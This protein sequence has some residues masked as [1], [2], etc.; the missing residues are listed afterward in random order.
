M[1]TML[2]INVNP[3][4]EDDLLDYLLGFGGVSGFTSYPVRGHGQHG[5]RMSLAEQVRGSRRRII[6]EVLL[7]ENQ[8]PPV[9]AGLAER[10]GRDITWWQQPIRGFGRIG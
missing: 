9:L 7:E 8:V 1:D 3:E 2:V 5:A 10:V 4:V 6:V